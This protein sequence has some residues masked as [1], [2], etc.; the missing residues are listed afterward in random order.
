MTYLERSGVLSAVLGD[1]G[2]WGGL[3]H[4]RADSGRLGGRQCT[5]EPLLR[6]KEEVLCRQRT[7]RLVLYSVRYEK[8]QAVAPQSV[9]VCVCVCVCGLMEVGGASWWIMNIG[10]CWSARLGSS[11]TTHPARQLRARVLPV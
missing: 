9:C 8:P 2:V 4:Q 10:S 11:H 7:L 5:E 6:P 1:G 3:T